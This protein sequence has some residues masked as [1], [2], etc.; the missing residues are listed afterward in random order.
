MDD[1]G[2]GSLRIGDARAGRKYHRAISSC[3]F[4]DADGVR[5]SVTLNVDDNDELFE[6][7]VWKVDFKPLCSWPEEGQFDV[8]E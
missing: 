4:D 1:G 8:G 5:V 3:H 2:M 6:L 7:D